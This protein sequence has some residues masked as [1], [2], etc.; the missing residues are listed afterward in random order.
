[1]LKAIRNPA[2]YHGHGKTKNFFEG[3]YFKI[4]TADGQRRYAVIPGIFLH[5]DP[6]E[7]HCF[8]QVLDGVS[9]GSEY[10]RYPIEQFHAAMET[11]EVTVG[12]SF[13][14]ADHI[15]LNFKND[16]LTMQGELHFSGLTPWINTL[17]SPGVMGWYSYIPF[18]ECYHGIVSLDHSIAGTL[19]INGEAVDFTGGRGYIEK[20]W[21]KS[22]PR[23]Y[24]WMQTNHFEQPG[25]CLT[26]SVAMIPWLGTEFRG[27]LVG[28]WHGG[29]LYRF[30]TYTGAKTRHV[31][32][33]DTHVQWYLSGKIA[34]QRYQLELNAARAKGGLLHAPYRTAMIQRIVESLT[35]SVEVCLR[36]D[37]EVIFSGTGRYAGLEVA[38]ELDKVLG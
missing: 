29:Q 16:T 34:G 25:T 1:M 28:L 13:F 11:F 9:G 21:G 17:L 30:T 35:A 20:D 36:R 22:F 26:A 24:I 15:R 2:L 8:V 23:G 32:L 18:M 10:F 6:T 12:E 4:V 19:T 14:S 27:F 31:Q 37:N 33:S 7:S 3:W 5:P 38:G